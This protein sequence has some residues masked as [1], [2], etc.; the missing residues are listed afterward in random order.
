MTLASAHGAFE[1][2]QLVDCFF[3]AGGSGLGDA[4]FQ[5]I[6]RFLGLAEFAEQFAFLE[7]G[8]AVVGI[9]S[10][11]LIDPSDGLFEFVGFGVLQADHV[12]QVG[13]GGVGFVELEQLVNSGH[14]RSLCDG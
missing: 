3:V 8:I 6:D 11:G 4:D 10:D 5:G 2:V 7:V 1:F 14:V 13:I 12:R 9:N